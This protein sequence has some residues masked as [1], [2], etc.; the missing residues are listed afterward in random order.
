[1]A[2]GSPPGVTMGGL[3]QGAEMSSFESGYL[4]GVGQITRREDNWL[5]CR[6]VVCSPSAVPST[7]VTGIS[8]SCVSSSSVSCS[9]ISSSSVSGSCT[10]SSSSVSSS[11]T[12]SVAVAGVTR[13]MGESLGFS[14]SS[15]MGTL[16]GRYLMSVCDVSVGKNHRDGERSIIFR[17][18]ISSVSSSTVPSSSTISSSSTV[19]S[20]VISSSSS[21]SGKSSSVSSSSTV[22]CSM[23]CT[24]IVA[25][26]IVSSCVPSISTVSGCLGYSCQV[27]AL[28]RGYFVGVRNVTVGQHYRQGLRS[29]VLGSIVACSIARTIACCPVACSSVTCSCVTC[30]SVTSCTT[31]VVR[32][33]GGCP[34]GLGEQ[35]DSGH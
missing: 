31:A 1:M 30:S 16:G 4:M 21:V 13:S 23:S 7:T 24:I 33:T 18:V 20:S 28:S 29:V 5:G 15:E 19:S 14:D 3:S 34:S 12:I 11:C 22:S 25:T 6:T 9:S 27:G 10:I 17:S 8:S 2:A 26:V 35:G 32:S